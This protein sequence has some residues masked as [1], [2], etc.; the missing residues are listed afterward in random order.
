MLTNILLGAGRAALA[1]ARYRISLLGFRRFIAESAGLLVIDEVI[2][3]AAEHSDWVKENQFMLLAGIS[4]PYIAKNSF[5]ALVKNPTK[6]KT[7]KTFCSKLSLQHP[8]SLLIKSVERMRVIASHSGVKILE[9]GRVILELSVQGG[10][11]AFTHPGSAGAAALIAATFA[12][13]VPTTRQEWEI[14]GSNLAIQLADFNHSVEEQS[15]RERLQSI[16]APDL[17][18]SGANI[19]RMFL[20]EHPTYSPEKAVSV[21]QNVMA[22]VDVIVGPYSLDGFTDSEGDP[23]IRINGTY[24]KVTESGDVYLLLPAEPSEGGTKELDDKFKDLLHLLETALEKVVSDGGVTMARVA[25]TKRFLSTP[26][27]I[28]ES[29]LALALN[30]DEPVPYFV[31]AKDTAFDSSLENLEDEIGED[32]IE[33]FSRL[34]GHLASDETIAAR[35][36]AFDE[37]VRNNISILGGAYRN[38]HVYLTQEVLEDGLGK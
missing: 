28:G 21:L 36:G 30:M 34:L 29:T 23:I 3:G 25:K 20:N 10:K 13:K 14:T 33:G 38:G 18:N 2:D 8:M 9:N 32:E 16:P 27:T 31:Y 1:L 24:Y 12:G 26:F 4:L 15:L 11:I 35:E 7:L 37:Y 6:L 17:L 5:F 22:R 19:I